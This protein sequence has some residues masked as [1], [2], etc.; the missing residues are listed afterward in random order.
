MRFG[1]D[2]RLGHQHLIDVVAFTTSSG[3]SLTSP[4]RSK[5]TWSRRTFAVAHTDQ[6]DQLGPEMVGADTLGHHLGQITAA[7]DESAG[8]RHAS[9]LQGDHV[10]AQEPAGEQ[11]DDQS[12]GP[13]EPNDGAGV[14][15]MA[16]EGRAGHQQSGDGNGTER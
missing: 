6:S 15:E 11:R 4:R 3:S 7:Q 14:V 2:V 10:R 9:S 12:A 5:L 8:C 13:E 1:R 16:Q